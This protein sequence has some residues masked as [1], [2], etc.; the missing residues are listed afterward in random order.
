VAEVGLATAKVWGLYMA[1]SRVGFERN[2]IELHHVLATK[3][4][5]GVSGYPLRHTF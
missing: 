1:G 2:D 3:T 4:V 5:D